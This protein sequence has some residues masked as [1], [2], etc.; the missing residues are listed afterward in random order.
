[1]GCYPLP[2]DPGLAVAL[3][4]FTG[5][6]VVFVMRSGKLSSISWILRTILTFFNN[7][8]AHFHHNAGVKGCCERQS[9]SQGYRTD[10]RL[11]QVARTI[12][13]LAGVENIS[14]SHV[15]EAIQD[16]SLDRK[17]WVVNSRL[18]YNETRL[19]AG[20]QSHREEAEN[21]QPYYC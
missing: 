3:L 9:V 18:C 19:G 4:S 1:M 14:T 13:E 2:A 21:T 7:I 8:P 12:A 5:I 16:R 20:R 6:I 11:S 10:G 15:A 17:F